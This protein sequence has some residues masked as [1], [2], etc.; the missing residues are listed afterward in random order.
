M[1]AALQ[2]FWN[3]NMALLHA[4]LPFIP[5]A[6]PIAGPNSQTL[7]L[8]LQ[9]DS[10]SIFD[11][12]IV[13]AAEPVESQPIDT[14][15]PVDLILTYTDLSGVEQNILLAHASKLPFTNLALRGKSEGFIAT[16]KSP[17]SI[18]VRFG[19]PNP[20]TSKTISFKAF[21]GAQINQR[22]L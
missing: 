13:F 22:S 9:P 6:I 1:G 17:V 15:A 2:P 4:K 10:A 20:P 14:V 11:A 7:L 12:Q 21:V 18:W 19:Y 5:I 8:S 3:L 16:E